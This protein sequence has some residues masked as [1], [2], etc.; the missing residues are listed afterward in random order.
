MKATKGLLIFGAILCF[1]STIAMLIIT[2]YLM[3]GLEYDKSW[4]NLMWIAAI[5]VALGGG[6]IEELK[7]IEEDEGDNNPYNDYS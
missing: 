7:K 2:L 3:I 5:L 1:L 4:W 6:A